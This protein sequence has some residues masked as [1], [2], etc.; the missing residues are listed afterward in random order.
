MLFKPV[1]VNNKIDLNKVEK[2][3]GQYIVVND[4]GEVY[5]DKELKNGNIVRER[6][7]QNIFINPLE[8]DITTPK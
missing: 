8:G 1:M 3:P 6:S 2:K 4:V 5:I 7:S